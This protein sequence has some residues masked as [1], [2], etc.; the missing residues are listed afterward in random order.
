MKAALI[1]TLIFIMGQ[2]SAVEVNVVG[3]TFDAEAYSIETANSNTAESNQFV[4]T[5]HE[6]ASSET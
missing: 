4:M 5:L 6:S 2:A 3:E 1:T